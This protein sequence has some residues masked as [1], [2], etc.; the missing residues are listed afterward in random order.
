MAKLQSKTQA[1]SDTG[2]SNIGQEPESVTGLPESPTERQE[3]LDSSKALS[4]VLRALTN[5]L[6]SVRLT[7]DPNATVDQN[8]D[9]VSLKFADTALTSSRDVR[10]TLSGVVRP[11]VDQILALMRE[12]ALLKQIPLSPI[13]VSATTPT[14]P[15]EGDFWYDTSSTVDQVLK[16]YQNGGW[17]STD[18]PGIF[19]FTSPDVPLSI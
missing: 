12:I 4:Y 18:Q 13:R 10:G 5:E 17:R 9:S 1:F 19:T 16:I 7:L 6:G 8:L 15:Q 3:R 11:M 14:N 2:L